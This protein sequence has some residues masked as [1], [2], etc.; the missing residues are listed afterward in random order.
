VTQPDGGTVSYQ[1]SNV[2]AAAQA[3]TTPTGSAIEGQLLETVTRDANNVELRKVVNTYVT[4]V[5]ISGAPLAGYPFPARYGLSGGGDD[6]SSGSVRPLKSVVTFQQ[7]VTFSKIHKTFD[8]LA[9]PLEVEKTSALGTKTE[10]TV[11]QDYRGCRAGASTPCRAL[12]VLGLVDSVTNAVLPLNAAVDNTYDDVG[13]LTQVKAFGRI[14]RT[15]TW[16]ADGTLATVTEGPNT[17]TLGPFKRGVPQSVTYADNRTRQ[18]AIDDAGD[19]R[20]ITNEVNET[21]RYDYDALR[22]LTSITYPANDSVAWYPTTIQ[23]ERVGTDTAVGVGGTHWKQTTTTGRARKV[24]HYDQRL[25]PVVTSEMDLDVPS[26][27]RHVRRGY[28]YAGR[29]T[30]AAYPSTSATTNAGTATTYDTLGRVTGTSQTSELGLL[31]TS[32]YYDPGFK[33]RVVNARGKTTTTAFQAFDEPDDSAPVE[34][35]APMGVTTSIGRDVF[36][37]PTSLTRSDNTISAT[38]NYVY[39]ANQRLCKTIEPES[40]ATVQAYNSANQ[41]EWKATGQ[42]LTS[43]TNCQH[44]NVANNQKVSYTYDARNRLLQTTY[45]DN[46]PNVARTYTA[47]GLLETIASDNSRWTTQYNKRRL[48]T[49]ETLRLDGV[50]YAIGYTHTRNGHVGGMTYPDGASLDYAPNALGEAT[51][52]GNYATQ[53]V[54]HPNGALG[55]FVYGNGIAHTTQQN[56]RGL[57]SWSID[58]NAL[59][60][61][62]AYDANANVTSITD[63][64][65]GT[66]TRTMSYDDRDRLQTARNDARWGGTQ[67]FGYD[68]LDN[69]RTTVAPGRTWTNR[70]DAAQRLTSVDD[71][72]SALIRYTHDGRGRVTSRTVR[73]EAT[74][75]FTTDLADRVTQIG[76]NVATYRYDGHGRRTTVTKNGTTTVQVYSQAG[77]LLY[78]SAPAIDGIFKNGLQGD[79]NYAQNGGNKR[80]IYLGRHLIAEDGTAGRTYIHTDGLGSPVRTT[81]TSGEATARK[82]YQPYGWGPQAQ[83][84]P[85]FTGHVAD[86]ETGLSYMQAR[87]YD[88]YAGRFLAV[89]PV[90]AEAETFNRYRYAN[91]NPYSFIDPDGRR[92]IYIGGA[93]DKDRTRIVQDYADTQ[94]QSNPGRDVQYF[95]YREKQEITAAISAPLKEGEPLNV[96]G[97][98]LGGREAIKQANSTEAKIT[99][100]VTIDPVGGAGNGT[101][102]SSVEAW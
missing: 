72:P 17:T 75:T 23:Y 4:G 66:F 37:K 38:R 48:S 93:A 11:Y 63:Q 81:N 8:V 69:L 24:T 5:D 32:T 57:P 70:Y 56:D 22:R 101:K 15:M 26:T 20:S 49:N 1:F 29:E 77:Q 14:D 42:N 83:S 65:G 43:T 95:S 62:Y 59:S 87:Y 19:I 96:I 50:D 34:I 54:T 39:D 91:N 36:G 86:A 51:K 99:N 7:G 67:T 79:Q 16:N 88:P 68:A 28:D 73:N 2:Y 90:S 53:I 12:W 44:T 46:S 60:D 40:G 61:R 92:D 76:S 30:F 25:R 41:I 100:L 71:G 82:D 98:S 89:D 47:D 21:T 3:G 64:L 84:T 85:G 97:H 6:P 31:T 33:T 18:A 78:Q 45:G 74:L 80:Y 55:G 94:K 13:N 9:R 52:V 102:P 10:T 35:A 27:Q 58:G